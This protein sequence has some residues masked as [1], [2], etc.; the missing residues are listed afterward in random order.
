V[1]WELLVVD[2]GSTD[3]TH[4]TVRAFDARLPVRMVREVRPGLSHARN[5]AIA[6]ARGSW[7]VWTDDDVLVLDDWLVAYARAFASTAGAI[8][9]GPIAP[10]FDPEPPAWLRRVLPRVGA[11]WSL[12]DH[13]PHPQ[14]LGLEPYRVPF[15]ANYATRADAQR[16]YP[17]DPRWGRRPD[18]PSLVGEEVAV[19]ESMLRDGLTGSWVPGARVLHR[20]GP[21]RQTLDY[22]RAQLRGYGA[23]RSTFDGPAPRRGDAALRW[24]ALVAALG[25]RVGRALGLPPESWIGDLVVAEDTRGRLSAYEAGSP[26]QR[27]VS[28]PGGASSSTRS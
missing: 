23:F 8:L 28:D 22:L 27:V 11:A 13:G 4:D 20:V 3:G 14:P 15:G 26:V 6:E 2:N 16:R 5:R 19:L 25:W 7:I 9:G 18:R 24:R 1:A 12:L 17:Y 21:E 10:W